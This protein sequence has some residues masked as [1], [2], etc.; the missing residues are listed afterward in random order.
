MLLRQIEYFHAIVRCGSFTDAAEEC[1]I[2]QSAISQQMQQLEAELG[3]SLMN[4]KNRRFSLTEAGRYFY[5][6]TLRITDDLA[7]ICRESRKIAAED[8]AVLR[9]AW[10]KNYGGSEFMLAVSSFSRLFPSVDVQIRSGTHEEIFD[11]LQ[12]DT[13]DL[14]MSDQR[15]AFSE[16][17]HNLI[18]AEVPCRI[19]VPAGSPLSE[20]ASVEMDNL[21]SETCILVTAPGQA[22][23]DIAYWRQIL[24]FRGRFLTAANL[25]EA[26]MMVLAGKGFLPIE[27]SSPVSALRDVMKCIPLCRDGERLMRR[28]CA[29]WKRDNSG[30]YVESFSE[31]LMQQFAA[32]KDMR[33]PVRE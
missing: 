1:H 2:S 26:K 24:G 22:E 19:E 15:R 4:R 32:E 13:V 17:Y 18:L 28:Y 20:Y 29:Y 7:Q 5:Q 23:N 21:G 27:G 6:E 31:I 12:K 11:W 30:Y 14:A 25:E 9:L 8:R 3:F 10:L 16:R 33:K